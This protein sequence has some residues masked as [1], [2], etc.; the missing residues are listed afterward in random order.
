VHPADYYFRTAPVFDA[1]DGP[2]AWLRNRLFVGS[3]R[4]GPGHVHIAVYLVT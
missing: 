2:H 4:P 3:A 1:P